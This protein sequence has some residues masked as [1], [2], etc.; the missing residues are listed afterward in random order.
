MGGEM[1]CGMKEKKLNGKAKYV[2]KGVKGDDFIQKENQNCT[3]FSTASKM[4]ECIY[5]DKSPQNDIL[6]TE[7]TV[8]SSEENSPMPSPSNSLKKYE[9]DNKY[10]L[11]LSLY[12]AYENGLL[13]VKIF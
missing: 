4:S 10:Q 9:M 7:Q 8:A 11:P 3:N 5:L 12:S 6:L 13:L 2:R 1:C